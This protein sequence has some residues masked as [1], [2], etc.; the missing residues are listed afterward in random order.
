MR[1]KRIGELMLALGISFLMAS[2]ILHI[3]NEGTIVLI[4]V[5]VV[6]IL[7]FGLSLWFLWLPR[8][9]EIIRIQKR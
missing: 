4:G 1:V 8:W 2:Y 5:A 3:F 7:F 9:E 6:G